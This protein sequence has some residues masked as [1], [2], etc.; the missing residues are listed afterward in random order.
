MDKAKR[1]QRKRRIRQKIKGTAERPRL[2]VFRSN[3]NIYVQ[4]ID[5]D[6]GITLAAVNSLTF[7]E[8]LTNKQ[9]VEKVAEEFA[10]KIL[11]KGIKT[12]VFDRNGF[13]YSG[14]IKLLAELLRKQGL[15]F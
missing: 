3:R 14:R 12:V 5:D 9:K 2:S 6:K 8:K 11:S 7:K 1:L 13:A 15:I 10:K 4:A